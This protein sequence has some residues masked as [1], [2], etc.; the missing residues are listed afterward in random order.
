MRNLT[1]EELKSVSG[2]FAVAV[3]SGNTT[4]Q[5]AGGGTATSGVPI[6]AN[7]TTTASGIGSVATAISIAVGGSAIAL[8]GLNV[9]V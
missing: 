3:L 2:G 1:T 8:G 7:A 5:A 9:A 6:A 4:K